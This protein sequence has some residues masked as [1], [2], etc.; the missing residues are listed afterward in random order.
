MPLFGLCDHSH[1]TPFRQDC[2]EQLL[3]KIKKVDDGSCQCNLDYQTVKPI[4]EE[5][6]PY[7]EQRRRELGRP[8]IRNVYDVI[9]DPKTALKA[10]RF[11]LQTGLL[12]QFRVVR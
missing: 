10:A 8:V 12:D 9:S 11:M 7:Q 5:C 1:S 2:P 3:F 4:I 6:P